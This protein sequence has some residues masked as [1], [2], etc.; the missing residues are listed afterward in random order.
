MACLSGVAAA[1]TEAISPDG[2]WTVSGGDGHVV[3]RDGGRVVRKLA[4]RSLGGNEDAA[5]H[6]VRHLAARRSFLISFDHRLPELWELSIDPAAAPV[7]DGLVH[8]FR[9]GEALGSPGFLGIRRIRLETPPGALG[10]DASQAYVLVRSSA[11]TPEG[12]VQLVLLN[13]D[14]RRSIARWEVDADPDFANL[15]ELER[16]GRPLIALPDR[17]GGPKLVVDPRAASLSYGD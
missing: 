14:V 13:L 8:D 6:A 7:F 2:R 16:R 15:V 4:A 11:N 1:A 5:V 17:R 3:V 10:V 9:M 12:Q